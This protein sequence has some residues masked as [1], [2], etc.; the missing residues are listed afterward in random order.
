MLFTISF[1]FVRLHSHLRP[2]SITP[3]NSEPTPNTSLAYSRAV[4]PEFTYKTK[5]IV[6]MLLPVVFGSILLLIFLIVLC[7]KCIKRALRVGGKTQKFCSHA[8]K[9]VAVYIIVAVA[10]SRCHDI[11]KGRARLWD[12]DGLRRAKDPAAAECRR[13][14]KSYAPLC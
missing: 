5:W 1:L 14:P 12:N 2:I 13:M 11:L 8:N 4:I 10:P 3:F 7:W 9:L 6:M